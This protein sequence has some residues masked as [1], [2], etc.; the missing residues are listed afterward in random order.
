MPARLCFALSPQQQE[1]FNAW[2]DVEQQRYHALFGDSFI[3]TIRRLG[4]STFR[5]AMILTTLRLI[6]PTPLAS[7]NSLD[8]LASLNSLDSSTSHPTLNSQLSTPKQS[9]F[10]ALPPQF[11]RPTYLEIA[12]QLQ[13]PDK[14]AEKQIERYLSANLLERIARG[15]FRKR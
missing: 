2:F 3:G 11:D 9:L 14:T 13:I 1:Q 12:T 8:S 5:I 4:L 7:V 15:I 6:N 10:Q